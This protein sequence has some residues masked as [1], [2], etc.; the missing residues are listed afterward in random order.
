MY[1]SCGVYSVH[2]VYTVCMWYMCMGCAY[3]VLCIQCV[4]GAYSVHEV[5]I[6]CVC[7]VYIVMGCRP[8][9][10]PVQNSAVLAMVSSNFMELSV[11]YISFS[12]IFVNFQEYVLTNIQGHKIS[13]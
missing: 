5:C 8:V 12:V 1:S 10:P 3:S 11:I 7:G 9:H 4:Y 13:F 2:V 6:L